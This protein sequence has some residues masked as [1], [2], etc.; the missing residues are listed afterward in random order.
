MVPTDRPTEADAAAARKR[1]LEAAI[2]S[3]R[4]GV[5]VVNTQSRRGRQLFDEA[6]RRL[7]ERGLVL[8]G[9]YAVRD[10]ARLPEIVRESVAAGHRLV[11]VGG[12]DGTI[13][14]VVDS[15]AYRDSVLAI[16]PLGTANSF[17][18][19]VGVPLELADA[20]D[21]ALSGKVA[22][23]D[24]GMVN[25]NYFANAAA[26]GLPASIA[27]DMPRML[28]KTLGR[29]GYLIV[30]LA[31]LVRHRPFRCTVTAD[32]RQ[33][34]FDAME[35][36]VANGA[37]QGGIR[38]TGEAGVESRDLVVQSITGRSRLSIARF[39]SRAVM[40]A[41]NSV[42]DEDVHMIRSPELVIEAVPPQ[43][44]SIDGEPV[45]RTPIRAH[46]ARQA[47]LLMVPRDQAGIH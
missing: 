26:I 16:L 42:D 12:G 27:R 25:D 23:V 21:V 36:R 1:D 19:A 14:S 6:Q 34:V 11:L 45:T 33:H 2:R 22:D 24:L 28:K 32:G 38:V 5:L 30:A 17:A 20:V 43:Y 29:A 47:L 39:W 3:Q 9:A 35:M 15:F 8:D 4:R 13:S 44:V 7:V 41:R 31:R 46:V 40:G 10:P 37:Y 18:R